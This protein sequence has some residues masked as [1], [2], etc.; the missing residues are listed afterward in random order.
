M[1]KEY[2]SHPQGRIAEFE[3]K[4]NATLELLFVVGDEIIQMR[5]RH[6]YDFKI[7]VTV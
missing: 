5:K 7:Y 6:F 1:L 3:H 4:T 2:I